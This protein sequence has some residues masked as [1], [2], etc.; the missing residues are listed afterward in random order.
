MAN[1]NPNAYLHLTGAV[2]ETLLSSLTGSNIGPQR[3]VVLGRITV[4]T[5]AAGSITINDAE[6][7]G[8]GAGTV[9]CIVD[10]TTATYVDFCV[11][12]TR[13]MTYTKVGTADVTITYR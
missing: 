3:P 7:T 5:G 4:N 1:E 9:V 8:T 11:Q 2:G 10:T 12:L 6:V 13:G